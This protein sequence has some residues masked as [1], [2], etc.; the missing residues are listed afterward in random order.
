[1]CDSLDIVGARR[2]MK[3]EP[4]A[5][6]QTISPKLRAYF[7]RHRETALGRRE[8]N[9]A[10][11]PDQETIETLIDT[12]FWASLRREEGFTPRISLAY[13]PPSQADHP[14]LL[15]RPLA[16]DAAALTRVA[17]AVERPGVHLGVWR[18]R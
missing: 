5:A 1:M 8:S 9:L 7:D 10:P 11:L 17:P 4:Y 13:L 12:A 16:I 14:L 2:R 3:R 15:E 6:A 18:A